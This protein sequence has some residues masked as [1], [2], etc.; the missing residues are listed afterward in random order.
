MPDLLFDRSLK[1]EISRDTLKELKAIRKNEPLIAWAKMI[2]Y[3]LLFK[4]KQILEEK[5]NAPEFA[6]MKRESL[7]IYRERNVHV[8]PKLTYWHIVV[9]AS[10]LLLFTVGGYWVGN[11]HR[12]QEN[13]V[14]SDVIEFN[15]PKG[16]QSELI[17][18]DGSFVALNYDS[19]LKYHISQNEKLQEVELEGE[20]FFKVFKNKSRIF[21]VITE[22]M[23]VNVLGT[24]FNVRAY[25]NDRRA[26]T[27]LLEGSI[28]IKDIVGG[29]E[30]VL[31]SPGEKWTYDKQNQ[32]QIVNAV[33]SQNS[34]SWRNGEYYFEKVSLGELANTL[35]RM[36]KVSIHFKAPSLRDEVYS[37]SVY[38]D[39]DIDQLFD[40]I[41][42]T[43]PI[44]I[45]KQNKEIWID[46]K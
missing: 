46:R 10:I 3:V 30:P 11:F 1:K 24:E 43:V 2:A 13:K 12:L 21:R 23:N 41:N 42:L 16:Q 27:T 34:T 15:T 5:R 9:A 20:A 37:G 14:Y 19:K 29:K 18:P 38:Q 8:S 32:N 25:K 35:E 36:Y 33:D 45:R 17:L 4:Q 22:H 26:E 7:R 6:E 28:E 40:I 44:R 31:L 39:D